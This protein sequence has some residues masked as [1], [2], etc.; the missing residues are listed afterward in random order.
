[1]CLAAIH[2]LLQQLWWCCLV[3]LQVNS[4]LIKIQHK[5][6]ACLFIVIIIIVIFI[7]SF[8]YLFTY[9]FYLSH[10]QGPL[11]DKAAKL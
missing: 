3:H 2:S 4:K 9:F 11:M 6:V 5:R 10:F 7:Y 8:I 1:M